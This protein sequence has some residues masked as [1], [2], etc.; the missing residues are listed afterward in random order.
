VPTQHKL[1]QKT[2]RHCFCTYYYSVPYLYR[3]SITV[4]FVCG[5][6]AY[7]NAF[8]WQCQVF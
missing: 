4:S 8:F 7:F 3:T 2:Y 6:C 1:Q 5:C